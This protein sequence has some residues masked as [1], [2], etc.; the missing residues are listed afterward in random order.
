MKRRLAAKPGLE[1]C[2]KLERLLIAA[3]CQLRL[4]AA[5]AAAETRIGGY[6]KQTL[7]AKRRRR[8]GGEAKLAGK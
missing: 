2:F 1:A 3:Q 5:I 6:A 7:V 8:P 4:L